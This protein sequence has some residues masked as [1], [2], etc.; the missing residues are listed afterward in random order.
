[1]WKW[2]RLDRSLLNSVNGWGRSIG[3][4]MAA[5]LWEEG[6]DELVK[7]PMVDPQQLGALRLRQLLQGFGGSWSSPVPP[8]KKSE[9]QRQQHHV[10]CTYSARFGPDAGAALGRLWVE[11]GEVLTAL[12]L[13]TC[14]S[15]IWVNAVR[16]VGICCP[17]AAAHSA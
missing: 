10:P 8:T 11:S 3:I 16:N 5:R 9:G 6:R 4:G 15:S 13:A 2:T 12:S 14:T 7:D 1:M 17:D